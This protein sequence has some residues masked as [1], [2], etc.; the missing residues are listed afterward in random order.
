MQVISAVTK[1]GLD[2]LLQQVWQ[3]SGQQP[4]DQCWPQGKNR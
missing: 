2:G 1:Q 4:T 3:H